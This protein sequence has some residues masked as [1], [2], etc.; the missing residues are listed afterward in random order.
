MQRGGHGHYGGG[1]H[2]GGGYG[3]GGF[4]KQRSRKPIVRK[5]IDPNST[6]ISYVTQRKFARDFRDLP[7]QY[8]MNP[9]SAYKRYMLPPGA[10]SRDDVMSCVATK[11]C[12]SSTNKQ[13]CP[14]NCLMWTPEGRRLI[15][16][17]SVGEF[18]LW[19]GLAFNFETILQAHDDAVRAMV[20]SHNDNWF[21]TADHGGV[22]KYW[23]SSMTNVQLVHGHRE[24][25][26][27]LSFSPTDYKFVS[28]SDDATV[29]IWDFESVKEER[30]LTGHGWDVKCVAY[31]PSKAL[32]ASG[33]KDNLVKIW[34]PKSGASLN[35]LHGH[36]NTVV[37]VAWNQ[38]GNWLL[39]ASRDQ[40]IKLYDIRTLKEFATMKGHTREV[41]SLAWHPIYEQ[42]FLSGSY[43]GSL[44]YWQVGQ[45]TPIATIAHAH[46]NAV[47]DIQWHP[48]GH[49]VAT[50]SNDHSTKFWSRNRPGDCMDDKYNNVLGE[51][52]AR[53]AVPG[54]D[55]VTPFAKAAVPGRRPPP[56]NYTCNRCGTKGHWIEDCPHKDE[57]SQK[58]PPPGY[59]CKRCNVAGHYIS[60]CPQAK[61]P[62]PSYVCH[63]CR[64]K[65]HWKQDCPNDM[66]HSNKRGAPDGPEHDAKR[67][68]QDFMASMVSRNSGYTSSTAQ[69]GRYDSRDRDRRN[70]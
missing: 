34:D 43:D 55:G 32:L 38:N 44:L 27:S 59:L 4:E 13:R 46:D 8:A 25:V 33:S 24:A 56:D 35:T 28:C 19:N 23:Q 70:W 37:K 58:A 21:V 60:D 31:H 6:F 3:G 17:N 36:K 29:K 39:T 54:I 22:I 30:V 10:F 53:G 9:H 51:G 50:G 52:D 7:P 61:I 16:G 40:L 62:P 69:H 48:A 41:T 12:R 65:G 20:W 57:M 42:L 14:V 68:E 5:C 26:R 11:F 2:D 63:K 1:H 45:E 67:F 15:T 64:Q 49:V 66:P 47:W 18:T